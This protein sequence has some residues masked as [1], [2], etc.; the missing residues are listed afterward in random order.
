MVGV[1]I[2]MGIIINKYWLASL[3][4]A[5]NHQ[6]GVGWLVDT[7]N[8]NCIQLPICPNV[9]RIDVNP[10][11]KQKNGETPFGNKQTYSVQTQRRAVLG[12]S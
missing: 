12:A 10:L 4:C 9:C 2:C 1:A 6:A 7:K 5:N 11:G 8:K 3:I